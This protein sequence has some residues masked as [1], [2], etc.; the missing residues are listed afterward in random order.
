MMVG[1]DAVGKYLCMFDRERVRNEDVVQLGLRERV[2]DAAS[3]CVSQP[4]FYKA[5]FNMRALT[6]IEQCIA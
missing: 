4:V 6:V 2:G 3:E 5:S 1:A